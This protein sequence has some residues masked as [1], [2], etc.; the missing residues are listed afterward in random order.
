M[1]N[2]LLIIQLANAMK[3]EWQVIVVD[4]APQKK[5]LPMP[6]YQSH[7]LSNETMQKFSN[8][9]FLYFICAG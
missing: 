6:E 7:N 3:V 5:E 8:V 1:I 4:Y 9:V 2:G